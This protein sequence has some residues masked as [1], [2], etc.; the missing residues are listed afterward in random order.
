[1]KKGVLS[2]IVFFAVSTMALA[3]KN[4]HTKF[5][6]GG[7]LGFAVGTFADSWTIGIG[8]SA[9]AEHF[10]T[11]Q[12]SGN[13]TVGIN[14]FFGKSIGTGI[15]NQDFT[16]IPIKVGANYWIGDSFH[17]GAQTGVG[18]LGGGAS[19]SGIEANGVAFAFSPQ[20]GYSFKTNNNKALDITIRYDAYVNKSTFTAPV[21]KL[22]YIF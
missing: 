16:I 7:E 15:K 18:I 20:I 14:S 11:E 4:G 19:R 22:S 8:A 6:V 13:A 17:A 10:F 3:Q 2:V 21:L 5:S 1:M 9:M 12:I